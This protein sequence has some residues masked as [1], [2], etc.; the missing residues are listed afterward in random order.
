MNNESKKELL[1]LVSLDESNYSYIKDLLLINKSNYDI[2]FNRLFSLNVNKAFSDFRELF[3]ISN[4]IYLKYYMGI[5]T[6]ITI[7]NDY[8]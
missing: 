4:H 3:Y 5:N 1:D 7:K 8:N 2:Y 6:R